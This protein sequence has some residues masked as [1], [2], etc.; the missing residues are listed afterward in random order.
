MFSS[1]T[2][3][4]IS[5]N[6]FVCFVGFRLSVNFIFC[7]WER[8]LLFSFERG[9]EKETTL[10]LSGYPSPN[11]NLQVHLISYRYTSFPSASIILLIIRWSSLIITEPAVTCSRLLGLGSKP[12]PRSELSDSTKILLFLCRGLLQY[13]K[14]ERKK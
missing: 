6:C 13:A 11:F 5:S 3:I 14:I 9:G 7:C 1:T 8:S 2:I 4:I 10:S 12:Y